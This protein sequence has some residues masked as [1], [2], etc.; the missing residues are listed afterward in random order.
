MGWAS[1][2]PPA[3]ILGREAC[4]MKKIFLFV[5]S[6]TL[7]GV[8]MDDLEAR[9]VWFPW[10]DHVPRIQSQ[11]TKT[12]NEAFGIWNNI[13]QFQNFGLYEEQI[14][15]V[16]VLINSMERQKAIDEKKY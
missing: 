7:M 4:Y 3:V 6:I 2:L 8:I 14:S 16:L 9:E 12:Q 11:W 10:L 1:K 13:T 5:I 15:E